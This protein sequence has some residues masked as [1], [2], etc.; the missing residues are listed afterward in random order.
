MFT[1]DV[2]S[3]LQELRPNI[4]EPKPSTSSQG[5]QACT[6][7]GHHTTNPHPSI[8][9]QILG[10]TWPLPPSFRFCTGQPAF[11]PQAST[12]LKSGMPDLGSGCRCHLNLIASICGELKV[13]LWDGAGILK[14]EG[15]IVDYYV[16]IA[17]ALI[18]HCL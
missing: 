5:P 10:F 9:T 11:E 2:D 4:P 16:Q 6:N 7:V 3:L 14:V 17:P 8:L 12:R 18:M 1:S 15:Y 13:N